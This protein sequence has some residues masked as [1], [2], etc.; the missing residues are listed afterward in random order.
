MNEEIDQS[1]KRSSKDFI[2][3]LIQAFL[4]DFYTNA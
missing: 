3:R 1:R 2:R 4:L